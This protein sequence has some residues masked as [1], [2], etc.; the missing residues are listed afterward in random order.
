MLSVSV[1]FSHLIL[2]YWGLILM[3]CS[4]LNI[5]NNWCSTRVHGLCIPVLKFISACIESSPCHQK[6]ARKEWDCS[7]SREAAAR[8]ALLRGH[9][10]GAVLSNAAPGGPYSGNPVGAVRTR[11]GF[12]YPGTPILPRHWSAAW[13]MEEPQSPRISVSYPFV[14]VCC[15][16]GRWHHLVRGQS[17]KDEETPPMANNP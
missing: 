17:W 9:C 13:Q 16:A 4:H 10:I 14:N 3:F 8:I 2:F 15:N 7:V 5:S 12:V 1:S 11:G 6:F